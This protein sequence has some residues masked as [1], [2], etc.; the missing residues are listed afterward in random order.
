MTKLSSPLF[1]QTMKEWLPATDNLFE[2]RIADDSGVFN[3]RQYALLHC[4]KVHFPGSGVEFTRN[5]T[6]R[7]F[8]LENYQSADEVSI[9]WRE[10]RYLSVRQYHEDWQGLFYDREKDHFISTGC[11]SSAEASKKLLKTFSIAI[12]V[13][14][15][16]AKD[17]PDFLVTRSLVL[18]GVFPPLLPELELA[19]ESGNGVEYT[20]N[21]KVSSWHW[22]D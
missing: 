14:P 16:N 7:L 12:Q 21:Y 18:E 20:L 1:S 11:T 15:A 17:S 3:A 2:V 5:R 22:E 19:W 9:T 6:T 13:M 8:Q 10:N 4:T